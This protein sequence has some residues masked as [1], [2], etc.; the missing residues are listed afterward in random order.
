[1]SKPYACPTHSERCAYILHSPIETRQENINKLITK[2]THTINKLEDLL[3]QTTMERSSAYLDLFT[4][5]E[6]NIDFI[7]LYLKLRLKLN[8]F[9]ND[10]NEIRNM[11]NSQIAMLDK[12]LMYREKMLEEMEEKKRKLNDDVI[13]DLPMG[14][15]S[16]IA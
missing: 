1:M 16:D 8:N 3:H 9:D 4:L 10:I 15:A 12:Q 7:F 14:L 13:K 11:K 5:P 6:D 2:L